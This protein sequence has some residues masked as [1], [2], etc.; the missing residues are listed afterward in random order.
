MLNDT[1]SLAKTTSTYDT[2]RVVGYPN[3]GGS[4]R[5][6]TDSAIGQPKKLSIKHQKQGA[7]VTAA[8]RHLVSI[9]RV[10]NASDGKPRSLIVNLTIQVPSD[11]TFVDAEV[12]AL[13][14]QLTFLLTRPDTHLGSDPI[15]VGT[16]T[17][18]D[19][20]PIASTVTRILRGES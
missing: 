6:A 11:G 18:A 16:F 1:I 2:Y 17:A 10:K 12:E 14:A 7:G 3:G 19:M 5:V 8:D 4:E 20:P 9:S 15:T 13:L